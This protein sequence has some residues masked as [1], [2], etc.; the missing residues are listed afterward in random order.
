[1]YQLN[2]NLRE[3]WQTRKPYKGLKGG[4]FSSKTQDAGGMAAYLARNYSLRF[5]CIRQFQIRLTDSVYTV[6]L[7]KINEAGWRDEFDVSAKTIRHKTTGSEFLFYGMARN[8]ADIKGTEGVDICWIEEGEGLTEEQWSIIDPTIRK[9]GAEVW[10]LW[11]PHL[12][13][14]FVQSKLPALLGDDFVVRHINYDENPFL[15]DTARKKAE[16][17]KLADPDAYNHIYLGHPITSDGAS[18]IRYEWV[19]A[20]V[21]AHVKL[22]LDMAGKRNVGYDVADG[23]DDKN[24][25]SIFDGAI[26]LDLDEW[27][28]PEDELTQS[29]KRAWA[30]VQGGTLVYDSI[31]VGA[32]VG[33]T[34]TDMG[35]HRGYS[36]FNAGGAVV[37]P[38]KL[39]A[40]GI[41]NKDKFENVKAQAWQDVA[42]R[43]RNT[44][45]AVTKG[46]VFAPDELISI[47]ST[48]RKLEQLKI[49]L[50]TPR[51]RYSKRGLDMVET[52]DELKARKIASPNCADSFIMGACPHLA[53]GRRVGAM[54]IF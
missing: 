29:T 21:D 32:H 48:C 35:V 1:M 13:T 12:M 22:G 28:A 17:L 11:N 6:V 2:P 46:E 53:I 51:R 10:I 27:A 24:A 16:R 31:G 3:F 19:E 9:E 50:A 26:C 20:A 44:F 37:D 38:D 4:R 14:D 7:Q 41:K 15:S 34:L 49:E 18:M 43:L 52:K 40:P 23:G 8:I 30:H 33:S 42:D 36:K 54:D 45:N 47:S 39:Y 5:L 25:A